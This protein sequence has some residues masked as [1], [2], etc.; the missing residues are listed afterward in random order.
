MTQWYWMKDGQKR[1]PVDTPELKRLADTGEMKPSDRI[2]REGL[3]AWVPASRAKGLFDANTALEQSSWHGSASGPG[4]QQGEQ[5]AAT[6]PAN[7]PLAASSTKV[8]EETAGIVSLLHRGWV[9]GLV[10]SGVVAF[11]ACF[12]LLWLSSFPGW[13]SAVYAAGVSVVFWTASAIL[14]TS[15]TSRAVA[16]FQERFGQDHA[17]RR[18]ALKAL[19]RLETASSSSKA[20]Y[21]ALCNRDLVPLEVR[22]TCAETIVGAYMCA[23]SHAEDSAAAAT[24]VALC[25]LH[26]AEHVNV[27]YDAST[28]NALGPSHSGPSWQFALNAARKFLAMARS[29]ITAKSGGESLLAALEQRIAAFKP[30][31]SDPQVLC[32]RPNGIPTGTVYVAPIEEAALA[33]AEVLKQASVGSLLDFV[34]SMPEHGWLLD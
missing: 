32:G 6:I 23:K 3:P 30:P 8:D 9:R 26:C 20:L 27:R 17:A 31:S 15:T 25:H 13:T 24:W 28:E 34:R 21:E 18:V 19:V 7:T 1:G 10:I 4:R 33:A 5:S 11:P 2:W 22:I 14:R 12:L 29:Q 16:S